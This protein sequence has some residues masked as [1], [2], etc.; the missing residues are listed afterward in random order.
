M[1]EFATSAPAASSSPP[2]TSRFSRSKP[3]SSR[4]VRHRRIDGLDGAGDPDFELVLLD[5]DRLDAQRRLELDL[6]E[7]LEVRRIADRE[8]QTLAALQDRQNPV[9]QQQLLVDQLDDLQVEIDG[10]E[11]EQRDAELVCRGDRDLPGVPHAIGHEVRHEIAALAL[12][13]GQRGHEIG[14]ADD[15]VLHESARKASQ[16][17]LGCGDRHG[18]F[19]RGSLAS[20]YNKH[21]TFTAASQECQ[22]SGS[23]FVTGICAL[24]RSP[25]TGRGG[26]RL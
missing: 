16:R 26:R 4:E 25:G 11:V 20:F 5:D 21:R 13:R 23:L 22:R 15:A 19:G 24:R 18:I 12:D 6:V 14:L 3:S 17:T 1:S 8:E 9:L 7:G 2:V 10:I